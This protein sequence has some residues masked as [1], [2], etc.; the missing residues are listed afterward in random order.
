MED[1][2]KIRALL[3]NVEPSKMVNAT[4]FF[5]MGIGQYGENDQFI[6]V[7]VPT[8]RKIAKQF[9]SLDLKELKVLI[10][11]EINE[12]RLLALFVLVGLY[13]KTSEEGKKAVFRFYM[14]NLKSI[15]NW[16]LVDAS[17]YWIVGAHLF[18]RDKETLLVLARS[19]NLWERRIAIVA[20]L[21]FIR[22]NVFEWTLKIAKLLLNDR[23]DLI[24][25]A[26]GWML[27]EVGKRN[28]NVLLNFLDVHVGAMPRIMLSYAVEKFSA[29]KK[30]IYLGLRRQKAEN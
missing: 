1:L 11:S 9:S 24:H 3:K 7:S 18:N 12:E 14:D 4:I 19:G 30:K 16:N 25:K 20:T 27:R 22:N 13:K 17:A 5:K 2:A 10:T 6:G 15:N 26:V 28:E 21:Y 8:L 23:Q 29:E